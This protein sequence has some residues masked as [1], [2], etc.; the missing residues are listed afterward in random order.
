L[1][2]LIEIFAQFLEPKQIIAEQSEIAQY[3]REWRDRYFGQTPIMLLP[4]TTQEVQKIIQTANEYGFKITTQ[5]GNTG[6]VGGQ[7]PQGEVLVC[8]K[9]MNQIIETRP[10]D[11]CMI[12]EAGAILENVQ[13]IAKENGRYFPLSL[14]SQGSATI[15]GL[16]ST[17]AGGVHVRKYGMMR[18]LIMG[19]EVVLPNGEIYQ[20]LSPLRKD[21][22]GYDLKQFFIGAEGTLG[23]I[24]KACLKLV[25]QPKHIQVCMVGF[26]DE[27]AMI[28]ALH[29]IEAN[30]NFLSAFEMINQQA[31]EFGLKNLIGVK[32][33]LDKIYPYLGLLEFS[34]NAQNPDAI[35]EQILGDLLE[36]N[37]I[38]DA[39]ISNSIS[40]VNQFWNLRENMSAAQKPEGRAAKHDISIPISK[41]P[42]F[43]N[44]AEL[45][46]QEIVNGARIAAFG[47][48]SDGNIHYD[49]A[50]PQNMEDDDFQEFV[51][52][53]NNKIHDIVCALG[54]SISAEHG[55]GIGRAKEFQ[56]REPITHLNLMKTIKQ[57]FDK[58]N[59]LNPRIYFN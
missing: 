51:P 36:D 22:T 9:N 35:I 13:N 57:S 24:T 53:I 59:I 40:Q 38:Y 32:N 27:Q 37:I 5:G 2:N 54:G 15:G 45:A 29:F 20:E 26:T 41:I 43:M 55:I 58:N 18:A 12:V 47:H 6:L 44:N 17:N 31:L 23:I 11:D 46:A 48:I 10:E 14:A 42:Q 3:L 50:R 1:Q 16:V 49:V 4:N 33:P 7:I 39:V 52:I 30:C 56:A 28:K 21:N 19:L 25:A 34:S 8:L